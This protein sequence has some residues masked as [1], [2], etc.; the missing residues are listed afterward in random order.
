[1]TSSCDQIKVQAYAVHMVST[2]TRLA[3][4]I[5]M[6][7]ILYTTVLLAITGNVLNTCVRREEAM[8]FLKIRCSGVDN[9]PWDHHQI[10][11]WGVH[12][13]KKT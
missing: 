9:G 4:H 8:L 5:I 7:I 10:I 11:L 12:K 1:M 2:L 13:Q 3:V 6:Y